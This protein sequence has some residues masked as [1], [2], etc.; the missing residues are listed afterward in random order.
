M[1]EY[2]V[3]FDAIRLRDDRLQSHVKHPDALVRTLV[4]HA[5]RAARRWLDRRYFKL[6]RRLLGAGGAGEQHGDQNAA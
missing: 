5:L 2:N 4:P 6:R 1:P 3:I